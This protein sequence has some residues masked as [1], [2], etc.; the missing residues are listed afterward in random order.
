MA[1][2]LDSIIGDV[3]LNSHNL[4]YDCGPLGYGFGPRTFVKWPSRE[5]IKS[6]VFAQLFNLAERFV[7]D[8]TVEDFVN[9]SVGEAILKKKIMPLLQVTINSLMNEETDQV[10]LKWNVGGRHQVLTG[11]ELL[12][13]M[14]EQNDTIDLFLKGEMKGV[15]CNLNLGRDKIAVG[16]EIPWRLYS[17]RVPVPFLKGHTTNVHLM[18]KVGWILDVVKKNFT[19]TGIAGGETIA[20]SGTIGLEMPT[21][22]VGGERISPVLAGASA[23]LNVGWIRTSLIMKPNSMSIDGFKEMNEEWGL[24][25][26][27]KKHKSYPNST[28]E[29]GL[30]CMEPEASRKLTVTNK[31]DVKLCVL[32]KIAS[33]LLKVKLKYNIFQQ[34]LGLQ[35]KLGN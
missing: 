7:G 1:P 8:V 11:L 23:V 31:G 34:K 4:R 22:L 19:V 17:F 2:L 10:G 18:T 12:A 25:L 15:M 5:Q 9:S 29:F 28:I 6:W 24:N 16:G 21:S 26:K 3:L 30:T 32:S 20:L 35:W 13:F 14:Q 33:Y 27:L